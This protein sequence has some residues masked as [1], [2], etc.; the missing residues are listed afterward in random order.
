MKMLNSI[1]VHSIIALTLLTV[2][3]AIFCN[4]N[5]ANDKLRPGSR[6]KII[7]PVYLMAVYN[8]LDNRQLSKETARAYLH[9]MQYYKKS[10]VAF[11]C[12]VPAGT[13]MTII[14]PAPKV[15]HLPFFADRYFVK[16]DP[17]LSQGLSVILELN[18][19][20]EGSLDGLSPELFNRQEESTDVKEDDLK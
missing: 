12:E 7:R 9:V 18:R 10:W 20:I 8:S 14:G 17:D 19:G 13:T 2:I 3:G 1:I 16:L 6:Y 11:Q 5:Y 4:L 15:W